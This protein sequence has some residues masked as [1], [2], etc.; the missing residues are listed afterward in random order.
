MF[1][2]IHILHIS[3]NINVFWSDYSLF[4]C[5]TWNF[6]LQQAPLEIL[7]NHSEF[8]YGLDFNLH[9]PGQVNNNYVWETESIK[10]FSEI[11]LSIFCSLHIYRLCVIFVFR[12]QTV[13][14]MNKWWS[15]RQSLWCLQASQGCLLSDICHPWMYSIRLNNV[16]LLK[17]SGFPL[18]RGSGNN[19]IL[20]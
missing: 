5:R 13:H 16:F 10:S 20:Y 3:E 15:T 17:C 2:I 9:V 4:I 6:Q 12:L 18:S 8:V 1:R 11:Y 19:C 7:E 14:G